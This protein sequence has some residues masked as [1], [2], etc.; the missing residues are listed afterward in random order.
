MTSSEVIRLGV[1]LGPLGKLN[2]NALRY[3]VLSINSLQNSFQFEIFPSPPEDDKFM[4]LLSSK[5]R[6]SQREFALESP[7]FMARYR[8]YI[9]R[10][11]AIYNLRD[12][13]PSHFVILSTAKFKEVNYVL[14]AGEL[15]TIALGDWKRDMAPPSIV[16]FMVTLLLREIPA[17]PYPD[18]Q[19]IMHLGTKGC[20]FDYTPFLGDV[21]YKVLSGHIC[22]VCSN[23][24]DSR[25][26][27][28]LRKDIIKILDRKWL[29]KT[30]DPIS[31][32]STMIKLG[33]NL[34]ITRGLKPTWQERLIENFQKEGVN[35][36]LGII[37]G[38]LLAVLLLW[39]GLGS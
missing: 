9:A 24:L 7:I 21:R 18:I 30:D 26:L 33:Y 6:L 34:F 14:R 38:I 17:V 20:L 31:P 4:Q 37:G 3:L 12:T 22:D 27:E 8:E 10:F 13:L 2:I 23:S 1:I 5:K 35:Q 16:E 19:N 36:I 15:T 25:G 29:G 11:L 39:L 32:V 28:E